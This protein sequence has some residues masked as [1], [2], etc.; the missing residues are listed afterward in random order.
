MKRI[1]AFFLPLM[2]ALS[3]LAPC[4]FAED[5]ADVL[6][7]WYLVGYQDL[8][9][10]PNV[11][12]RGNG[13]DDFFTVYTDGETYILV[14]D[15]D[16]VSKGYEYKD[17]ILRNEKLPGFMDY[18]LEGD[19]L[20]LVYADEG[21]EHAIFTY[22]RQ[23]LDRQVAMNQRD[24]I[25]CANVTDFDGEWTITKYGM[26]GAFVDAAELNMEGKAT[27]EN[28]HMTLTWTRDGVQKNAELTF[29]EELNQGRLYMI[30]NDSTSYIVTKTDANTLVMN[31][32]LN[33][34]Q[35]VFGK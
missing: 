13:D 17:G 15:N 32:G 6:G 25:S 33:Q 8:D 21:V 19:Q 20:I 9:N 22:G 26:N 30:L 14:D 18:K 27:I 4:A 10:Y 5:P 29:D 3:V 23:P 28:G 11:T 1:V 24:W 16:S 12:F 35:W 2:L 34:V 31:I 7:T